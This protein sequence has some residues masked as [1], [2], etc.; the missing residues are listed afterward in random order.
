M[1]SQTLGHRCAAAVT[2]TSE[3]A[4]SQSPKIQA[5]ESSPFPDSVKRTLKIIVILRLVFWAN[6]LYAADTRESCQIS[7]FCFVGSLGF[8]LSELQMVFVRVRTV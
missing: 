3:M 7:L 2:V 5:A 8:G 4:W 6:D 1:K